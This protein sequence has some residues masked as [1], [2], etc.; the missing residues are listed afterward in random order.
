[1]ADYKKDYKKKIK[2][3][4]DSVKKLIGDAPELEDEEGYERQYYT[5][6]FH[7]QT[8]LKEDK[9]ILEVLFFIP[10][11]LLKDYVKLTSILNKVGF[12]FE[13]K[14]KNPIKEENDYEY[15]YTIQIDDAENKLG[16]YRK[17]LDL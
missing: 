2:A 13:S 4:E 5:D 10:T 7:F 3:L 16:S 15:K 12:K 6:D 8:Y 17:F 1:M 14:T 11:D 9:G